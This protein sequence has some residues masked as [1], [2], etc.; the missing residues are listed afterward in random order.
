MPLLVTINRHIFSI[1]DFFF[2]HNCFAVKLE[3][4]HARLMQILEAHR[5]IFFSQS[6]LV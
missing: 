2:F 5:K 4:Y 3:M 6:R 1:S